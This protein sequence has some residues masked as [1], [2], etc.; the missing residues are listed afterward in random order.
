M[1]EAVGE[2][3]DEPVAVADAGGVVDTTLLLLNADEAGHAFALPPPTL[4]WR[5][6]LDSDRP[7]AEERLVTE[8]AVP[9][10][11]HSV[12]LLAARLPSA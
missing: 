2:F 11:P 8:G 12:V 5:L 3:G 6:V 10:A 4:E 7:E 9:V 1:G